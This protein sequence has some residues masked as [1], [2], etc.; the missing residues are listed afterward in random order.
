[1]EVVIDAIYCVCGS[2]KHTTVHLFVS[3]KRVFVS[4]ALKKASVWLHISVLIN[5]H[6]NVTASASCTLFNKKGTIFVHYF[7]MLKGLF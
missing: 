1:M 3:V 6:K 4:A 2:L 7:L 5:W